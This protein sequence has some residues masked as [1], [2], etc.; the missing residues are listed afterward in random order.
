M[1]IGLP[2]LLEG[3]ELGWELVTSSFEPL[4]AGETFTARPF[5]YVEG[6]YTYVDSH[7]ISYNDQPAYFSYD[8]GDFFIFGSGEGSFTV[9]ST[10]GT[11]TAGY[12][13][14][15]NQH[16]TTFTM[17]GTDKFEVSRPRG[18]NDTY[19]EVSV[20]YIGG[21]SMIHYHNSTISDPFRSFEPGRVVG[22]GNI[23]GTGW[24]NLVIDSVPLEIGHQYTY[25]DALDTYINYFNN[26]Y[27]DINLTRDDFPPESY[28]LP[29]Q[30][31]T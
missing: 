27:T 16:Y 9:S 23:S 21:P 14:P 1:A 7:G 4:N 3:I 31:T 11:F 29:E 8:D 19:S 26:K 20:V 6:T 10:S 30:P 22:I 17:Q 24:N 5:I 12:Y 13:N 28:F 25:Y 2:S 18:Y 15:G